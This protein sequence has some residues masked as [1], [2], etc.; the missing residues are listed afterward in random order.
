MRILFVDT[1]PTL[2]WTPESNFTKG[3]RRFPALSVTG[4]MTYSYLNLQAAAVLAGPGARWLAGCGPRVKL[5][6]L[7][8][9]LVLALGLYLEQS[10]SE[11]VGHR[12]L[13]D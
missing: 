13:G 3:G 10:W 12:N 1:P 6:G 7:A 5:V 8:L 11:S 4:E 9:T 2:D